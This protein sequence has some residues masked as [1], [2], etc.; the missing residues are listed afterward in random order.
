VLLGS[1]TSALWNPV[2]LPR[3]N[4]VARHK[5]NGEDQSSFLEPST[6]PAGV[7]TTKPKPCEANERGAKR[8]K[9]LKNGVSCLLC[10]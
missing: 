3:V 10:E 6:V 9:E 7:P 2:L 1:A 5:N 8:E 4:I